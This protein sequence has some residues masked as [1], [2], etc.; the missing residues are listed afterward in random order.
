[1]PI[2]YDAAWRLFQGVE[3]VTYHPYDPAADAVLT[4]GKPAD[5]IFLEERRYEQHAG[6]DGRVYD[7]V[8]QVLLRAKHLAGVAVGPRGEIARSDGTRWAVQECSL[9][10]FGTRFVCQTT[11]LV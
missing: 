7:A 10:T 2:D 11:Q 1:M 5:A 8:R 3:R 9:R 4:A 6:E